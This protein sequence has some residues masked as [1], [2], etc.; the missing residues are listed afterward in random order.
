LAWAA[1]RVSRAAV[2]RVRRAVLRDGDLAAAVERLAV[3][4][5][6]PVD[7]PAVERLAALDR[8]VPVVLRAVLSR[9]APVVFALLEVSA[10]SGSASR[11]SA[12][13]RT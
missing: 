2:V 6:V 8:R 10:M 7:R 4:R 12:V 5:L 11:C 9:V 1:S 3:E 13:Y